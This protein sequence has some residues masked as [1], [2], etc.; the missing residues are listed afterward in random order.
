MLEDGEPRGIEGS[1]GSL[2]HSFRQLECDLHT[3]TVTHSL[4]LPTAMQEQRTC[5]RMI[6]LD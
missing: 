1:G 5:E 6:R 2:I 3:T 4:Y